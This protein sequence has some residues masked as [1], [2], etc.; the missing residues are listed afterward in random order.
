MDRAK[1]EEARRL[2]EQ[3]IDRGDAPI[4]LVSVHTLLAEALAPEDGAGEVELVY[5][6]ADPPRLGIVR[7]PA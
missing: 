6:G 5:I 4:G 7:P 3:M 1:I 2:V